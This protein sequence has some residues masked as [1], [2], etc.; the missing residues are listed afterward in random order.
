LQGGSSSEEETMEINMSL[1]QYSI[2]L[3]CKL[4]EKLLNQALMQRALAVMMNSIF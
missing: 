3:K 2:L 4:L 1:N